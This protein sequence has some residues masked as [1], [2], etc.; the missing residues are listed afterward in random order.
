MSLM[1]LSLMVPS[2]AQGGPHRVLVLGGLVSISGPC[3]ELVASEQRKAGP[4]SQMD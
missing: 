2:T 1:R 4:S 3:P